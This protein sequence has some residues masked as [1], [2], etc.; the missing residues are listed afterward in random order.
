MDLDAILEDIPEGRKSS[1]GGDAM[2]ILFSLKDGFDVVMTKVAE[3][4]A[5]QNTLMGKIDAMEKRISGVVTCE[6][7]TGKTVNGHGD[8]MDESFDASA[9]KH[10]VNV[11]IKTNVHND[12]EQIFVSTDTSEKVVNN[13]RRVSVDT[14]MIDLDTITVDL[15]N[16]HTDLSF[17]NYQF[18]FNDKEMHMATNP[19]YLEF[20]LVVISVFSIFTLVNKIETVAD[21]RNVEVMLYWI[22]M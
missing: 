8:V 6:T 9:D 18:R 11:D 12:G 10:D 4:E 2:E 7:Q 22:A 20:E 19:K 13:F 5:K 3:M 1:I 14:K 15:V 16:N 21:P 17:S